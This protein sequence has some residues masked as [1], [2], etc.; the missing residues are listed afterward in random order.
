MTPTTI[1][2]ELESSDGRQ[3]LA[4]IDSRTARHLWHVPV[5]GGG[6]YYPPRTADGVT[7]AGIIP[8]VASNTATYSAFDL[9]DGRLLWRR[10]RRTVEA[11]SSGEL[12]AAGTGLALFVQEGT[13]TLQAL[14]L[15]TGNLRWKRSLAG[16][17]PDGYSEVV[18]GAGSVAVID[19][20]K[21]TVLDARD[22]TL[23][24]SR[25][26]PT[27]GLRAHAPA[28]ILAGQLIIPSISSAWTPY[29][30]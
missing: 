18:A 15:R 10:Y 13:H 1:V 19:P 28:A 11:G 3:Q 26:L 4:G 30:E 23:R 27:A 25:P 20:G 29:N 2:V 22:G 5:G 9:R 21:L 17:R 7:I 8:G 6:G 24:W 14:D 16:W 12:E